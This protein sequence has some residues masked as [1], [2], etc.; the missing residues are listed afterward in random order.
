MTTSVGYRR[1]PCKTANLKRE[2]ARPFLSVLTR[3]LIVI[4]IL[5]ASQPQAQFS[6]WQLGNPSLVIDLPG[7]PGGGGV[8]WHDSGLGILPTSWSAED[9]HLRVEISERYGDKTA[10]QA[11]Q[12]LGSKLQSKTSNA[13]E[14]KISGMPALRFSAGQRTG[15]VIAAEG[16]SW[17]VLITPKT[18]TGAG[19]VQHVLGSIVLE[20]WGNPRWVRRSV[21]NTNVNA[22]MPYEMAAEIDEPNPNR[23]SYELHFNDISVRAFTE[24]PNEGG[25]IDFQKSFDSYIEGEK[26]Q[27]GTTDFSVTKTRVDQ[28]RF[29]GQGATISLKRDNKA[30]KIHLVAGMSDGNYV[31]VGAT[32]RGDRPDHE[33]LCTR[34]VNSV[35]VSGVNFSPFEPRQIGNEGIWFDAPKD[36]DAPGGGGGRR[37]T[38][39]YAGG[40]AVDVSLTDV[41]VPANLPQ[42]MG[43]LETKHKPQGNPRDYQCDFSKILVDGLEA[44]IMRMRFKEAG[45]G[46]FTC[47]YAM[48]IGAP[49]KI[50]LAE[51]IA[52]ESQAD[53]LER[54]MATAKVEVKAPDGWQ[55]HAIGAGQM[56]MLLS[57]PPK[58]DKLEPPAG[59]TSQFAVSFDEEGILGEAIETTYASNP[60]MPGLKVREYFEA[61][62]KAANTTGRIVEQ[63]PYQVGGRSGILAKLSFD[64]PNG[65]IEGDMVVVTRGNT[66]WMVAVLY[67]S[68]QP[69]SNYR[70]TVILNSIK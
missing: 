43:F 34:I 3:L 45:R 24:R 54:F 22:E 35:K 50:I 10:Q 65:V 52:N 7:Q 29:K 12:E 53:Y 67:R 63:R 47:K 38:G 11:A 57:K 25:K 14:L 58:N 18:Q 62:R 1:V 39:I 4:P 64:I 51:M 37:T 48:A 13:S 16:R 23:K 56:T 41:N 28:D 46:D 20:R 27:P 36:F 59:A 55:R 42:L 32:A 60:P 61:I 69:G 6:R 5:A 8:A 30:Y 19:Q 33:G 44:N 21:G 26:N 17:T 15:V 9:D 68:D 2:R 40:F 31:R 66:M 70:R 49:D